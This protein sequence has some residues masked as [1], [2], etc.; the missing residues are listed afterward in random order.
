MT[1]T[2]LSKQFISQTDSVVM[3][4]GEFAKAMGFKGTN[5]VS[6]YYAHL[7]KVPGTGKYFCKD[8]AESVLG[9]KED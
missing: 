2:E 7:Q 9:F 6:K 3:S 4:P 5:K 8:L 1:V